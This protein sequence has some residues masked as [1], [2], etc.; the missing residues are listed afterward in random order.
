MVWRKSGAQTVFTGIM[1]PTLNTS[2]DT[3]RFQAFPASVNPDEGIKD[4]A[5]VHSKTFS[6]NLLLGTCIRKSVTL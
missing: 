4:E 6:G 1:A 5:L 3:E 2:L